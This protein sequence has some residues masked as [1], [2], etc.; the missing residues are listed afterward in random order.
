MLFDARIVSVGDW[1]VVSVVGD[2]DL[3]TM[4]TLRQALDRTEAADTAI[5][6]S[7]VDHVDPVT[8][9]VLHV[10]GLRATRARGRF[11]VVCPPG[12]ARDLLVATGI[13]RV[14]DVVDDRSHL[15]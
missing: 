2:L 13:D 4:P 12:S 3:A 6:L 14:L 7:G 15:T 11:V 1:D 8:L 5:D 10:A 9:G